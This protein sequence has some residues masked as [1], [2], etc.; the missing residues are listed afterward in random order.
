MISA[1]SFGETHSSAVLALFLGKCENRI[2]PVIRAPQP[3]PGN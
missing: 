1:L 3:N 2:I